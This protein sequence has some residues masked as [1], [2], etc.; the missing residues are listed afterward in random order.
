MLGNYALSS[1]YYDA[2]YLRSQKV[3][4]LIKADFDHAFKA[5]D[6]ILSPTTPD[7]AFELGAKSGDPLAMY[8]CDVF[9]VTCN[10]AGIPGMSLPCGFSPSGLPIGMQLLG[11]LFS[12]TVLLRLARFY[13]TAH[14]WHRRKPGDDA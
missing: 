1:G 12:E 7:V 13:E 11:P 4:Q 8:L 9:T 6:V 5:C 14:D 10:I 2:Y 3:R